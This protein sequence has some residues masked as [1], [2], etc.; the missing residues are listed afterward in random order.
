MRKYSSDNAEI[1]MRVRSIR[2]AADMTQEQFSEC[3]GVTGSYVSE[4]ERGVSG[5]SI[6]TVKQIALHFGVSCDYILLGANKSES[7]SLSRLV[8]KL[9]CIPENKL[10]FAERLLDAFMH[11]VVAP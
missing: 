3:I 7:D 6:T 2:K 11:A 5:I 4:I 1:G 8:G 10:D 9:Q